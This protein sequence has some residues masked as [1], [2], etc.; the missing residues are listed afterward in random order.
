MGR[1]QVERPPIAYPQRRRG[2]FPVRTGDIIDL[3]KVVSITHHGAFIDLGF[4]KDGLLKR[5]CGQLRPGSYVKVR[6]ERVILRQ[7]KPPLIEL[8]LLDIH[9]GIVIN[10][11]HLKAETGVL[12][13]AEDRA[14]ER[15]YTFRL[16]RT[17]QW[18]DIPLSLIAQK[19]IG[20]HKLAVVR[21]GAF[22]GIAKRELAFDADFIP[23]AN[24]LA[25]AVKRVRDFIAKPSVS[26]LLPE[27]LPGDMTNGHIAVRITAAEPLDGTGY[28][29]SGIALLEGETELDR[30]KA[31]FQRG[32]AVHFYLQ[33]DPNVNGNG[34]EE[35]LE[36]TLVQYL[37]QHPLQAI[38][39]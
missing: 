11:G 13:G 27:D 5:G 18:V 7:N 24:Q 30:I 25:A 10:N 12:V 19:N 14:L 2:D 28:F 31:S 1:L 8:R 36:L 26:R 39:L 6:V 37:A 35:P 23:C 33:M 34:K 29:P 3:A 21:I 16:Q 9:H 4:N 15:Y 20:K 22:C 17:S 32:A 38:L